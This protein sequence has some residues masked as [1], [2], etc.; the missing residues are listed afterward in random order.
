M[1]PWFYETI[2]DILSSTYRYSLILS[3]ALQPYSGEAE[4]YDNLFSTHSTFLWKY[5][6]NDSEMVQKTGP[7]QHFMAASAI[8]ILTLCW[9]PE[10][11]NRLCMLCHS[12]SSGCEHS[13][14]LWDDVAGL[15]EQEQWE[16]KVP[17]PGSCAGVEACAFSCTEDKPRIVPGHRPCWCFI[18]WLG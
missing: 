6:G 14:Q 15:C 11:I 17:P 1:T 16:D 8:F 13:D 12:W 4:E 2:I 3:L 10:S 9:G 7:L 5:C 18:S